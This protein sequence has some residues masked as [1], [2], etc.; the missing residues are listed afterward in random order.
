M[1][2]TSTQFRSEHEYPLAKM[3]DN[4]SEVPRKV[5][6][7]IYFLNKNWKSP[8]SYIQVVGF[9][10]GR[11]TSLSELIEEVI[12]CGLML[13]P[14]FKINPT[15]VVFQEDEQKGEG[16][17]MMSSCIPVSSNIIYYFLEV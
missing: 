17:S 1:A 15:R 6:N 9:S 12:L 16:A 11:H 8:F 14:G 3:V 10:T 2:G 7:S 5:I 4:F 13:L